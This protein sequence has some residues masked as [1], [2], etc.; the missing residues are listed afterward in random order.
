MEYINPDIV[1]IAY[2]IFLGI[3]IYITFNPNDIQE[4]QINYIREEMRQR[5]W[6]HRR[7]IIFGEKQ[8]EKEE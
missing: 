3:F 4:R 5:E 6:Q 1:F 8:N 2:L 7:E